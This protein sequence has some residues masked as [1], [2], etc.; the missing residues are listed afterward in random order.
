MHLTGLHVRVYVPTVVSNLNSYDD[1]CFIPPGPALSFR[2]L[3]D[4]RG[5]IAS[6]NCSYQ[7]ERY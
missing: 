6:E 2:A 5:E 3:R 1:R 7:E 4:V